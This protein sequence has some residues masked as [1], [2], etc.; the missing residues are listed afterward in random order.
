V[1]D[2]DH[3]IREM[4][5]E[6]AEEVRF[7]PAVPRPV[8]RRARR[9]RVGNAVL[10]S[11][12]VAG[13]A[14]GGFIGVRQA[15]NGGAKPAHRQ[16]AN[17]TSP[18]EVWFTMD[19]HLFVT[20]RETEDTPQAAM[21]ALLQGPTEEQGGATV[22]SA[23][24]DGTRLD[25]LTIQDGTARVQLSTHVESDPLA[26]AQVVYTLTQFP[27]VKSVLVNG[28]Q[29]GSLTRADFAGQLPA[30]LLEHPAI[31]DAVTS[32]VTIS[33]TADVFEGTVSIRV[34]EGEGTVLADT[35]AQAS[36]GT[37]CRGT[38][39]Q[40]V[41]YTLGQQRTGTIEVFE[42]SAENGQPINVV[43]IPVTLEPSSSPT[44]PAPRTW[45]GVWRPDY[46]KPQFASAGSDP[47]TAAVAFA[48]D[49]LR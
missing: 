40:D 29:G 31:G 36:C 44:P 35:T 24:P 45:D 37:G 15:L 8:L 34:I 20:S 21:Q 10:A 27:D 19:H 28:Q 3:D 11:V 7:D 39:S 41:P 49:I 46:T 1:S 25:G 12:L 17:G 22:S 26:D 42:S 47:K 38:F 18:H 14:A 23:L 2:V 43:N 30:I 9:R 33:G 16:V 32:P 13:V 48:Q 5:R 4:L 6:K